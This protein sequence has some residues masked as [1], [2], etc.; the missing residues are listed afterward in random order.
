MDWR[1]HNKTLDDL[2]R[3]LAITNSRRGFLKAA[4]GLL[5]AGAGLP[6]SAIDSAAAQGC[7]EDGSYCDFADQCC[8]YV[9]EGFVCGGAGCSSGQ[10]ASDSDCCFP[11]CC[12]GWCT[13]TYNDFW[14]CGSCGNTCPDGS[15]C[16]NYACH[17][18]NIC[19]SW[20]TQC[21]VACVDLTSDP[22][23]CGAC[24]NVCSGYTPCVNAECRGCVSVAGMYEPTMC[25][26]TCVDLASDPFNCG[27]CGNVCGPAIQC[28]VGQCGECPAGTCPYLSGQTVQC[29]DPTYDVNNCGSCGRRCAPGETC[30]LGQCERICPA[31]LTLCGG[32]GCGGGSSDPQAL[33]AC[34]IDLKSD[35]FNCGQCFNHCGEDDIC[36]AGRCTAEVTPV[37]TPVRDVESAQC[38][39]PPCDYLRSECGHCCCPYG[40][41]CDKEG[42]SLCLPCPGGRAQCGGK[43]CKASEVCD[44]T[45][46]AWGSCVVLEEHR[47]PNG[48]PSCKRQCDLRDYQICVGDGLLLDLCSSHGE[49]PLDLDLAF[50]YTQPYFLSGS[51]VPTAPNVYQ[52]SDWA[53]PQEP[54]RF[55]PDARERCGDTCCEAD[56]DCY[57][58]GL[59]APSGGLRELDLTTGLACISTVECARSGEVCCDEKCRNVIS[60]ENNCGVCGNI[61]GAGEY[62]LFGHCYRDGGPCPPATVE[63]GGHCCPLA[64]P[65]DRR[66]LTCQDPDGPMG[67]GIVC[68]TGGIPKTAP[69]ELL[70]SACSLQPIPYTGAELAGCALDFYFALYNSLAKISLVSAKS[71]KLS[72]MIEGLIDAVEAGD[73]VLDMAKADSN[74]L[75]LLNYLDVVPGN[76]C[77]A[78]AVDVLTE[79]QYTG[80]RICLANPECAATL[81]TEMVF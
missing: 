80:L 4:A 11:N 72:T 46:T 31:G 13:D 18:W 28:N 8:S 57:G 76:Q 14:N 75:R 19:E 41:Y 10:C 3:A 55:C 70:R 39:A 47:C 81:E 7:L 51:I 27:S 56:E 34:C 42:Q 54:C 63:C 23:N 35:R 65:C 5:V 74:L 21:G 59:C 48:R 62:C 61:C 6:R 12:D 25:G 1:S 68:E 24:G 49:T 38:T 29:A 64:L 33:R 37:P 26:N 58:G 69:R 36:A 60:D 30:W 9:C 50:L 2:A 66:T 44:R 67:I 77:A 43:C 22:Y 73:T 52:P 79:G 32:D 40:W 78:L 71:H 15:Y 17:S 45:L 16:E 53:R 20:E